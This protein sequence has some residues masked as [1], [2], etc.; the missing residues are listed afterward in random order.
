MLDSYAHMVIEHHLCVP[1]VT[2][3]RAQNL[4][5]IKT[6]IFLNVRLESGYVFHWWPNFVIHTHN[7]KGWY[8]DY[9]EFMLPIKQI[10][11]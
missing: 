9:D 4:L 1:A 8:H 6:N 7:A 2:C 5:V 10:Q 11:L 3:A